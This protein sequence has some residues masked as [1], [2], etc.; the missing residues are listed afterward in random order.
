V[1]L[2]GVGR[3]VERPWASDGMVGAR[4]VTTMTLSADHR[5]TD[6]FTG[7]RFLDLIDRHLQHPEDL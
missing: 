3:V 7:A 1:A 4:P 2:V 5:V 6:G